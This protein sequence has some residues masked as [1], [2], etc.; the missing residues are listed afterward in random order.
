[1][2]MRNSP[3]QSIAQDIT[4]SEYEARLYYDF[5]ARRKLLHDA[6]LIT[7]LRQTG[8]VFFGIYIYCNNIYII[9]AI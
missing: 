9:A 5:T 2:D 4:H 1:M 3:G 7:G 6:K 8:D